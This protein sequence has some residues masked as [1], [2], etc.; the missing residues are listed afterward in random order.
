MG[1]AFVKADGT[2]SKHRHSLL[3][4]AWPALGEQFV[5]AHAR[6]EREADATPQQELFVFPPQ[7]AVI[8]LHRLPADWKPAEYAG[9]REAEESPSEII[10]RPRGSLA[11]RAFGT[12]VH[13][14]L[15]DLTSLPSS[16]EVSGWRPRAVVML[17]AAGLPR[18]EAEAQATEVIR[19]LRSVLQ[20]PTGRWILGA[21]A[22]ARSEISWSTW[23]G[24]MVRTLRGDRIFQAGAEPGS[25]GETYLWVVDYKTA[26]HGASGLDAFLTEE[27]EKYQRQLES[28]ADVLRKVPGNDLPMRLALYFPLLTRLVWW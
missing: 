8:K 22:G 4:I 27:K 18:A 17:R 7:T 5:E 6:Q 28:Y 25:P 13:G 23:A 12:V 3:G 2:L 26:R 14:L 24:D 11:T 1:T 19:T 9:G 15:E 20:D 16:E 10:E 21:R